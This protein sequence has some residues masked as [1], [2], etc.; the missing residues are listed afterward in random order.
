[1][2]AAAA[3]ATGIH[4]ARPASP[5]TRQAVVVAADLPA[6]H[7]LENGD[8]RTRQV[9]TDMLP[10]GAVDMDE[11]PVG[12]LLA[13]PLRAGQVLTDLS[14]VSP[15]ALQA[16]PPGTV[17]ATVRV[18]DP[19]ATEAVAVG[20]RVSVIGADLQARGEATVV[21]RRVLVVALPGEEPVGA[22]GEG[23]PVVV[24]VDELTALSLAEAAI[25]SALSVVL[26]Q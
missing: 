1:L 17:L 7:L 22:L 23:R 11:L 3:V 26:T 2:L 4:A 25:G 12:R 21:A 9:V 8:V 13:A 10:D 24:A 19:A 14:V 16:H 20:D 15:S 5:D 18:T 6:G